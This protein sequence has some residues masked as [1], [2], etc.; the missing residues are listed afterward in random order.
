[1]KNFLEYLSDNKKIY[2]YKFKFALND[3]SEDMKEKFKTSLEK[4]TLEECSEFSETPIQANP[5]DF[6]NTTNTK[7]FSAVVKVKYPATVDMLRNYI[8]QVLHVNESQIAVY[9][10]NDP[11]ETNTELYNER[12]SEDFKKNYVPKL[13]SMYND[14]KQPETPKYGKES[15]AD[16]TSKKSEDFNTIITPLSPKQKKDKA[17]KQSPKDSEKKAKSVLGNKK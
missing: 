7:V 11:R 9:N 17:P 12:T 3:I 13:G 8:S 15:V 5:L 1:M 14:E 2:E 6:P 16:A 10:K 4:Y